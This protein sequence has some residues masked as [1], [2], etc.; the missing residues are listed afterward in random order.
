MNEENDQPPQPGDDQG[1]SPAAA[2]LPIRPAGWLPANKVGRT[3]AEPVLSLP[4]RPAPAWEPPSEGEDIAYHAAR[5]AQERKS[6]PPTG[7]P[8]DRTRNGS[9]TAK[10]RSR[11]L[12]WR[13][14]WV[15]CVAISF[16]LGLV[17]GDRRK[18]KPEPPPVSTPEPFVA[19]S[20][21]EEKAI[22]QALTLLRQKQEEAAFQ[23][24]ATL[25]LTNPRLSSLSYLTAITAL[26]GGDLQTAA[27]EVAA[28]R[29]SGEKV[30]DVY[31]LD[32]TLQTLEPGAADEQGQ[33][34]EAL[35]PQA[36]VADQ[37]NPAPLFYA[38]DATL[39]TLEPGAA[40]EQ[41]QRAEALLRQA[42]V[43]DQANPAPRLQ[44]GLQM[45]ARGEHEAARAMLASARLRLH[46]V[47]PAV[48]IDTTLLLS[49]LE[50]RPTDLLPAD[51]D[52][53]KSTANLLGAAYV[54]MR[55][56]DYALITRL[57]ETA[58]ARLSPEL[59]YFLLSDRAFAPYRARPGLA[60]E[61]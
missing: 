56:E 44:L 50:G 60:E 18:A 30:S 14:I 15:G 24:I 46:P 6:L 37:A 53:D 26:Q 41:V 47:D 48:T 7:Q 1:Q 31:A 51:L 8:A 45:R 5:I 54:A 42:I 22:N 11:L 58:R 55:R 10:K 40:D 23:I 49:E 36:I 52:P 32:A 4:T 57:L 35:L 3:T 9:Q 20:E 33:R 43:A 28:A 25:R 27:F 29:Q 39:Q 34:A 59:Y 16:A 12:A 13:A 38:L 2:A 17:V 21:T 19:A 61:F